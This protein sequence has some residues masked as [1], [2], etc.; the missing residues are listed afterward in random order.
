MTVLGQIDGRLRTDVQTTEMT[1]WFSVDVP[2]AGLLVIE[3]VT[4]NL[5]DPAIILFDDFG[6]EIGYNDDA[7]G[8]L[9]SMLAAR[10]M[11]GTYVVGVKQ[12][13]G[14]TPVLTRLLFE[15]YLPA[16]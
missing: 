2:T 6:R 3:A 15:R 13:S 16:Q 1:S 5:G 11:P 4:N 12:L 14:S 10:V 9:D 8:T 7:N